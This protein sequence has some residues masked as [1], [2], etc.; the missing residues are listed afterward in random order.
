METR[1][2]Q[3]FLHARSALLAR[4]REAV[5]TSAMGGT[6]VDYASAIERMQLAGVSAAAA[7]S[8]VTERQSGAPPSLRAAAVCTSWSKHLCVS[9]GVYRSRLTSAPRV[10]YKIVGGIPC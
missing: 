5:H 10:T 3:A 2:R 6:S 1:R 8:W 4:V 7:L 9:Q